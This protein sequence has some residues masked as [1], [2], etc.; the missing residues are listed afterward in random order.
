MDNRQLAELKAMETAL[1]EQD[2]HIQGQVTDFLEQAD[3]LRQWKNVQFRG[4]FAPGHVIGPRPG[5]T[6]PV[7]P[8]NDMQ[9]MLQQIAE[10]C[11]A[12]G[13][14]AGKLAAFRSA[15]T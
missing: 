12:R 5:F 14:A 7:V 10:K 6:G 2:A 1:A 4:A 8:F 11:Q 13:E 3:K 9:S 15:H